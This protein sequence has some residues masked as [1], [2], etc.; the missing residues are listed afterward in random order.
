M[1]PL[2]ALCAAAV[3]LAALTQLAPPPRRT[4]SGVRV[5]QAFTSTTTSSVPTT[6][7]CHDDWHPSSRKDCDRVPC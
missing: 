6:T 1:R 3:A 7:A 2:L 5:A 4:L